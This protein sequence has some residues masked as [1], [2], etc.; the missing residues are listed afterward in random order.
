MKLPAFEPGSPPFV[1]FRQSTKG[2]E[3]G[4]FERALYAGVLPLDHSRMDSEK[5]GLLLKFW[6]RWKQ[7]KHST[8]EINKNR[9]WTLLPMF[10]EIHEKL[11]LPQHYELF[12]QA[13][14]E[15][16]LIAKGISTQKALTDKDREYVARR[17]QEILPNSGMVAGAHPDEL[18]LER[19]LEPL[20]IIYDYDCSADRLG[21]L[22]ERYNVMVGVTPSI[23]SILQAREIS[24][25][26]MLKPQLVIAPH[27]DRLVEVG[28]PDLVGILFDICN[29]AFHQKKPAGLQE[30][31]VYGTTGHSTPA[32]YPVEK[33]IAEIY[34]R[35]GPENFARKAKTFFEFRK[36]LRE[37][38]TPEDLRPLIEGRW[39]GM[40]GNLYGA[41]QSRD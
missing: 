3:G 27:L 8:S 21:E 4:V 20:P 16:F 10:P 15:S 25:L 37:A 36:L 38:Q 2:W 12:W 13:Y 1:T 18:M 40:K 29:H 30:W 17:V 41:I 19:K 22:N 23:V 31:K 35:I 7:N 33:D 5:E 9:V 6:K 26:R 14:Q 11:P 39:P 34:T 28:N 24:R 32:E